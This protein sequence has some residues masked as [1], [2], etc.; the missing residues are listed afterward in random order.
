MRILVCDDNKDIRDT[1]AAALKEAC[2]AVDTAP[3][4][5]RGS[6]LARTNDY[7]C[8]IMDNV[9]PALDGLS[10]CAEIRAHDIHTP[11]LFLSVKTDTDIKVDALNAGA[12]D[13]LEKPFAIRELIARVHA[14]LRRAPH[15]ADDELCSGTLCLNTRTQT[16]R[17]EDTPITLTRK[18]FML[19]EYLLRH[20][21]SVLSRSMLIEHVWDINADPFSNTLESH[22]STLRRKLRT[23]G[24][25]SL[26]RT[27]SGRGYTIDN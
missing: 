19:L 18:E 22:I 10:A 25:H 14:L 13:Y 20:R 26:I 21:G 4:G 15:M 8:I 11:I 1:V 24:H 5:E 23:C 2:F 16:V 9:M 17:C 27:V 7:D 6:Y 12:D 3:D